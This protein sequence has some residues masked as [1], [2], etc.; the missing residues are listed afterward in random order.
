MGVFWKRGSTHSYGKKKPPV[1]G[2]VADSFQAAVSEG[3]SPVDFWIMTP[4]LTGRATTGLYDMRM[5]QA[6]VQARM[7][8]AKKLSELKSFLSKR[9][10]RVED[11]MA[12]MKSALA[13][14]GRK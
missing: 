5:K 2:W 9:K 1:G 12:E 7:T 11:R 14:M 8:R 3:I 13:S 10:A 6:W 4:Y